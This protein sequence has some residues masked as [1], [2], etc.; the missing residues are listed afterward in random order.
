MKRKLGLLLCVSVVVISL[1]SLYDIA[2]EI[3]HTCTGEHCA[4]CAR[5]HAA[6]ENLRRLTLGGGAV[7]SANHAGQIVLL[8]VLLLPMLVRPTPVSRKV[9]MDD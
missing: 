4:V 7:P 5:I 2:K 3:D 8:V 9:R 6:Q 1:F